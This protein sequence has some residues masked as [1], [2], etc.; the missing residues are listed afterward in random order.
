MIAVALLL[1]TTQPLPVHAPG[2]RPVDRAW[3]NAALAVPS[4]N[5]AR[6]LRDLHQAVQRLSTAEPERAGPSGL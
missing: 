1:A 2:A 5:G 6:R 3:R 4:R